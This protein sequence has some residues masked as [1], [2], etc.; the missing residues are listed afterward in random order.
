M[1]FDYAAPGRAGKARMKRFPGKSAGRSRVRSSRL[2]GQRAKAGRIVDRRAAPPTRFSAIMAHPGHRVLRMRRVLVLSAVF[3]ASTLAVLLVAGMAVV[4]YLVPQLPSPESL[5]DVSL[6]VP[7]RVYD[8]DGGMIAEFGELRRQPVRLADI[9]ETLRVAVV[10]TEDEHFHR[11]PGVDWRGIA[12]ALAHLARTREKG[13]GGSTI[14]MQVAR[15]FFLGREKTYFRKLNEILLAFSIERALTKEEILEL[16]LNKIFLGHRAYGVAAA[17]EVYYGKT[18]GALDLAQMA[19]IAGLPQRPSALNPIANPEGA[20]ARRNH[21]LRRLAEVDHIDRA[22]AQAA[23]EAPVTAS[24]H[25]TSIETRAPYVAE[26]VRQEA[27]KALG[28]SAYTGAY[29]VHTT[30][31][32]RLQAAAVQALR[33]ALLEYDRRHGYRGPEGRIDLGAPPDPARWEQRLRDVRP[34]GGLPPAVVVRVADREAAVHVRGEGEVVLPWDAMEWA[35]PFVHVNRRGPEPK[36]AA[37][38]LTAGDL[39]RVQRGEDGW[40]LAQIP[41]V[42]GALVALDPED[43]AILAMAGGFDFDRSKFNRGIQARRQP[44]SS[45][46][47][48]IYASA[49]ARGFTA[50]S[51]VND[52]PVVFDDPGIGK[53]WRPENYSGKFFGPTRLREALVNS[54]NLVSIRLTRELGLDFVLDYARRFGFDPERLPRALSIAL[55]SGEITPLEAA[56]AYSVLANGGYAVRPWFVERIQ[57]RFAEPVVVA[58]PVRVCPECGKDG[59]GGA[60]A[61]GAGT[62]VRDEAGAEIVAAE[63]VVPAADVWILHSILRDVVRRGTGRRA[64]ALGRADLAGKTGTTNDQYDAWFCGFVPSL[65]AVAWV[66]F[67]DHEPLGRLEVGG[68]AALPMWMKFMRVALDGVP[69]QIPPPPE[70]L[71]KVRID[72]DTGRL[73][74]AGDP[75]SLFETFRTAYLPGGPGG[76]TARVGPGAPSAESSRAS[77][78]TRQLF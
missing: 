54:R 30:I 75:D 31:D 27:E 42:E 59:G 69:E 53:E 8:R 23:S 47:P 29:H 67:D 58:N 49:L 62:G 39:I 34:V 20:R 44:G 43:G 56:T 15:N 41:K 76:G 68:R 65:V 38:V 4:V 66:G 46:K 3:A 60:P 63:R 13:P 55:G 35:R 14:T 48:F 61:A 78:A 18:L 2:T 1:K 45:F 9:P 5:R 28:A 17:A 64:Q 6:R 11:H 74:D 51:L 21:V 40:R 22:A 71:V 50:A 37:D 25:T 32:P 72:P 57:D 7:L 24:L 70:G 77:G 36:K 73:A 33:E 10:A 26:M 12:R 19:M 16:Y 52:A